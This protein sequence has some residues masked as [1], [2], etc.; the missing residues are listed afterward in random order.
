MS[1]EDV[2]ERFRQAETVTPIS[3]RKKPEPVVTKRET[4]SLDAMLARFVQIAKGPLIVDLNNTACRL[5]PNEFAAAYAHCREQI[6]NASVPITA[7]WS[8]HA[9]RMSADV[10]TLNPAE[11]QFFTDDRGL[12]HFNTWC[13]PSWPQTAA[14]FAKPFFDHLTYLI[15]EQRSRDDLIDWLA[16]A[17][18]TPAVRP[19]FH[20]LLVAQTA[21]GTGRS[22][23]ADLMVRLFSPR[24]AG[25]IDLHRLLNETFNSE[26]SGKVVMGV[27]EVRAPPDERFSH[28]DRLKSLLT[29]TTL[30]VNEKF[31]PR[32]V[33]RFVTRFLMFTNKDD[34]IPLSETDRRVYA[35]RCADQPKDEVYYRTLYAHLTDERFLAAVWT[36][37]RERSPAGFNPGRRAPENRMKLQMIAAGRSDEQQTAVELVKACP[38]PIVASDDL[39]K[40]LVPRG[41]HEPYN[42]HR[43]RQAAV[44]AVLKD[45]GK[46]TGPNKVWVDGHS[47]RVWILTDPLKWV[48]AVPAALV[49]EALKA[50]QDF[51][52]ATW[53]P[54]LLLGHWQ[55]KPDGG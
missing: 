42:D 51:M 36:A 39:M 9:E 13:P 22:W 32:W 24:H 30:T 10:L 29:D 50:R 2:K 55:R 48:D 21:E 54:D 45:L 8:Q 3:S 53:M 18:Q 44:I 38:H 12:R 46:Q 43:A 52:H 49:D 31:E 16:H 34:A 5:R 20:F 23:L 37:L 47:V 26:L 17:A 6:G 7:L 4:L 25:A 27:H 41:E 1:I 15:P 19:H 40:A 14:T 28:R 35:V 11:G 33:E